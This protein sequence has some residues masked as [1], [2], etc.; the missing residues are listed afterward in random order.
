MR[1]K[2]LVLIA[3]SCFAFRLAGNSSGARLMFAYVCCDSF[4]PLAVRFVNQ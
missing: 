1:V 3:L 2:S 4:L